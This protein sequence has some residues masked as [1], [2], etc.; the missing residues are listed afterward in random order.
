MN[1]TLEINAETNCAIEIHWHQSGRGDWQFTFTADY[2]DHEQQFTAST[3]DEELVDQIHGLIF[4]GERDDALEVIKDTLLNG[5]SKTYN[6]IEQWCKS[7]DDQE[8]AEADQDALDME[9]THNSLQSQ[10]HTPWNA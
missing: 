1:T 4:D 3:F 2:K 8:I 10:F 9:A 7:V 6:D 5:N